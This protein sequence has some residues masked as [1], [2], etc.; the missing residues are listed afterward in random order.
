MAAAHLVALQQNRRRRV[1]VAQ[2]QY[3]TLT[4]QELLKK[5]RLDRGGIDYLCRELHEDLARPTRRSNALSVSVQVLAALRYFG[6][7][8]FQ[9]VTG[10]ISRFSVS[11]C[12]HN[13]ANALVD[14]RL[15]R[16]IRF[17]RDNYLQRRTK[18][19]FYELAHFPNVLGAVDGTLIP[20]IAPSIDEHLFI[21][22]KG[23]HA[24]NTQGVMG[25]DGRFLNIVARWPGSTHDSF[26]WKNSS[27]AREMSARRITGGWL[28]GDS[29]YALTPWLLN[30]STESY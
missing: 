18:E 10:N 7:G 27:L 11:R 9:A 15:Q 16:H 14:R 21:C 1:Q 2:R 13:V 22:R 4:D 29:A 12:V 20:V 17:P 19:A 6:T 3:A 28:L 25:P 8:S 5:Y 24:I 30:P 26:I 23:Y